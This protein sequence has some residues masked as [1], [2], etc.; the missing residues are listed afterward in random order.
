MSRAIAT[1]VTSS[2]TVRTF[3]LIFS[4]MMRTLWLA[5]LFTPLFLLMIPVSPWLF[6]FSGHKPEIDH[7]ILTLLRRTLVACEDHGGVGAI[8]ARSRAGAPAQR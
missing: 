2:L 6:S 8:E 4:S 1:A 7:L 5:A 3:G